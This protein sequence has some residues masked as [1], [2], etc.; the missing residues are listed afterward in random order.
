MGPDESARAALPQLLRPHWKKLRRRVKQ[1]R[2]SA[3]RHPA[4]PDTDRFETTAIRHG[5]RR[6]DYG[7]VRSSDCSASRRNANDPRRPPRRGDRRQW[8]EQILRTERRKPVSWPERMA[9]DARRQQADGSEAMGGVP[10]RPCRKG[11]ASRIG[12][13]RGDA[14][15]SAAHRPQTPPPRPTVRRS[16][17][18]NN[19]NL[20]DLLQ[21]LR[22]A[23]LG[24]QVLFGFLLSLPFTVRFTKL[25]APSRTSTRATLLFTALSTALLDQPRGLPPVGLPAPS[26]GAPVAI[27]QCLRAPGAGQRR[28]GDLA[29]NLADHGL[30]RCEL[31][32]DALSAATSASFACCGS[33]CRSARSTQ[34]GSRCR[35]TDEAPR[36]APAAQTH[37]GSRRR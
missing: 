19:R 26:K 5:S 1:G 8:L 6:A 18:R 9:A 36:R 31:D 22:V 15:A 32:R 4:A 21:E 3:E 14:G 33:R 12:S 25:D 30:H 10:G 7:Q 34:I 16:A 35:T 24:V 2:F 13:R 29:R 27:R 23:G 28:R 11:T 17:E 37:S 20:S